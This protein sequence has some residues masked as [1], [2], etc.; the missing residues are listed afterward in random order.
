M[1]LTLEAGLG[2][3]SLV[4]IAH[5]VT[6]VRGQS[7]GGA[8]PVPGFGGRLKGGILSWQLSTCDRH[9]SVAAAASEPSV[10]VCRSAVV[11]VISH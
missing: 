5:K 8:V 11:L 2:S 9:T 7:V 1:W 4:S 6:G 10:I 3:T